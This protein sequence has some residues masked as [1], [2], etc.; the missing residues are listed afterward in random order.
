MSFIS[1]VMSHDP[2]R[3]A[4]IDNWGSYTYGELYARVHSGPDIPLNSLDSFDLVAS[5]IRHL[6]GG[7][8]IVLQS[9]GTTGSPKMTPCSEK[10]LEAAAKSSIDHFGLTPDDKMIS[11]A[12]MHISAGVL[13]NF[14]I[15]LYLGS[16]CIL[17]QKMFSPSVAISL[18]REHKP[19]IFMAIP[20][21]Y[22]TILASNE[23]IHRLPVQ[24]CLIGGEAYDAQIW[25][26]WEE[27]THTRMNSIYGVSEIMNNMLHGDYP[28]TLGKP[29]KG[30]SVKL[31]DGVMWYKGPTTKDW[32]C[33]HDK[34]HVD[35]YGNYVFD[36]RTVPFIKV[37]GKWVDNP[38]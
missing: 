35:E 38:D 22:E 31:V 5:M 3:I 19:K 7:K 13:W 9:S 1:R 24:T 23:D 26:D 28:G 30:S 33:T 17:R 32:V 18:I 16:T 34:A 25:R 21:M 6:E 11:V 37:R 20:W 14:A 27:A 4:V 12:K 8:S 15:P 10:T 29:C 36:G 2:D